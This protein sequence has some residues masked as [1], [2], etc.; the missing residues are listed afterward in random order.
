MVVTT[1]YW[2]VELLV[3]F[4]FVIQQSYNYVCEMYSFVNNVQYILLC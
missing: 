3:D 4:F 2:I 1:E